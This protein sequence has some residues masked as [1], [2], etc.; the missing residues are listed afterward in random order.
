MSVKFYN[1]VLDA[2]RTFEAQWQP[3]ALSVVDVGFYDRFARQ[4]SLWEEAYATGSE[5]D[6]ELHAGGMIR[7]YAA[8]TELLEKHRRTGF[9]VG[10]DH[11]RGITICISPYSE[12]VRYAE[13]GTEYPVKWVTPEA[14]ARLIGQAQEMGITIDDKEDR[15]S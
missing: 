11:E 10:H 8:A 12:S 15:L 13:E 5:S 2:K 14:V 1:D 3:S 4:R 7:A 9:M 6:I